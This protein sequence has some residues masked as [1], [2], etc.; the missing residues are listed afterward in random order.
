MK[1][2]YGLVNNFNNLFNVIK[3]ATNN[4]FVPITGE[5]RSIKILAALRTGK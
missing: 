5:I 1:L 4:I 2:F 3:N